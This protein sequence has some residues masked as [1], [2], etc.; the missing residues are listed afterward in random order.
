MLVV[1]LYVAQVVAS[2]V[3]GFADR[4]GVVRQVDVAVVAE[5]FGHGGRRGVAATRGSW[6]EAMR[7][8]VLRCDAMRVRE[9]AAQVAGNKN[10]GPPRPV[11]GCRRRRLPRPR[12]GARRWL[13]G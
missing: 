11:G 9:G 13:A 2:R 1:G 5:E 4:H 8:D 7:C 12:G 6:G 10:Q 3:V